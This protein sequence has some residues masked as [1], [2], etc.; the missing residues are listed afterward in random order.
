M[1]AQHYIHVSAMLL[2]RNNLCIYLVL[3]SNSTI[4]PVIALITLLLHRKMQSNQKCRISSNSVADPVFSVGGADPLGG[5]D[6]QCGCFSA[7]T[8]AK[9]KELGSGAC[10]HP[11][12]PPM[13]LI[14]VQIVETND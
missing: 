10:R 8:C 2:F 4:F 3:D 9:I 6:L 13:Q 14:I 5:A 1:T 7:E 11:L 12:D